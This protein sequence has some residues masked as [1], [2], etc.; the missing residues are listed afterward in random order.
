MNQ[1]TVSELLSTRSMIIYAGQ[2]WGFVSIFL[3]YCYNFN[4][5]RT[6]SDLPAKFQYTFFD[7][8]GKN[9]TTPN[10]PLTP[11]PTLFTPP[12]YR[13]NSNTLELTVSNFYG[14]SADG[15]NL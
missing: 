12:V 1:K 14:P 13:A 4:S 9:P 15:Q 2:L 10:I 7:A 11:F 5:L 3:R 8:L 6:M